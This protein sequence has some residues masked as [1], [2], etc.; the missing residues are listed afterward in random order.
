[1]EFND[2]IPKLIAGHLRGEL[3]TREQKELD[4]WIN[5]K[6]ANKLFFAECTNE[7][8]LAEELRQFNKKDR[9]PILN[10]TLQSIDP[11]TKTTNRS[12]LVQIK[13]YMAAACLVLIVA[14]VIYVLNRN[15][16][17]KEVAK[18]TINTNDSY[19][20]DVAPGSDKAILTLANGST[21][22][23]SNAGN[24][25]IADENGTTVSQQGAQLV[26]DASQALSNRQLKFSYN[27]LTTPRGG[28][29]HVVLP[30]GSRVWLNAVSSI[31]YPTAFIGKE[32]NVE[33]TGEA[34]FEVTKDASKPF[35]VVAGEVRVE[36]L[37]THFNI[38]S[39]PDESEMQTTLLEGTVKVNTQGLTHVLN[40]GQA[41]LVDQ[42]GKFNIREVDTEQAVAW[43]NNSFHFRDNDIET[44]MRQ[45]ARWYDVEIIYKG[46]VT[47]RYTGIVSRTVPV[48]GIL[49]FLE[50][51]GG[52]RFITEGNKV[53]VYTH[54][55]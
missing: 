41:A 55:K 40:P 10:N 50:R 30:D 32:R 5:E 53:I 46:I 29:Y 1:M 47:K 13:R 33:I 7:K 38:N 4:D 36:V 37:G 35:K 34:Y 8:L 23:L 17:R 52:V 28:Q 43:K 2:R 24:K 51:S 12:R 48:S 9:T 14:T 18:T 3:T 15:S 44:I 20:N 54:D 22:E 25:K 45:L 31:R 49:N 26:Y 11:E 16:N 27:V 6:E 21:I 19:K 39:F 42:N